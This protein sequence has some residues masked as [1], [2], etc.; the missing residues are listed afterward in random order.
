[1]VCVHTRCADSVKEGTPTP[2]MAGYS[3]WFSGSKRRCGCIE[4]R[5]ERTHCIGEWPYHFEE[6]LPSTVEEWFLGTEWRNYS[7]KSVEGTRGISIEFSVRRHRGALGKA[8]RDAQY[9]RVGRSIDIQIG[10]TRGSRR[11]SSGRGTALVVV[12]HV[13][14][15]GR[16]RQHRLRLARS[17]RC[18]V[19]RHCGALDRN[20]RQKRPYEKNQNV[21]R[22]IQNVKNNQHVHTPYKQQ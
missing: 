22:V 14:N 12:I 17:I 15:S 8:R 18:C 21:F 9:R 7:A 2:A 11:P 4:Q 3:K 13:T 19:R 6:W 1:M 10:I 16:S 5:F 20:E